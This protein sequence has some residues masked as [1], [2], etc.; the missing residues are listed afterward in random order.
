LE[1]SYQGDITIENQS[2]TMLPVH[3]RDF[4]LM[5]QDFALFPHMTVAENVAFGLRMK[6][7]PKTE[8][9]ECIN[10][11]LA[12]VGLEAFGNR[13]VTQLSGGEKQRVALARSLAPQPR[14]LML[15]EPLGSLDAGLR[16]HLVIELRD[17][18]KQVGLTS[19]YVT[20]D[21]Q[22]AYAVADRI[23]IIHNGRIEQVDTPQNL[24]QRPK[25]PFVARFLGLTNIV[26]ITAF[27]GRF[28]PNHD[29]DALLLHPVGMSISE[30]GQLRG[31]IIER[32]FRGAT[33][34]LQVRVDSET[35]AFTVSSKDPV[36]EIHETVSIHIEENWIVPLYNPLLP[37]KLKEKS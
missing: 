20:H 27:N 23:A 12:L 31:T 15:D 36:P 26:S 11:V 33:Y 16:D 5:F 19:I 13:D 25:T 32:V 34:Q 10:A 37:R 35:L 18:I 6:S 3:K 22:E 8:R 29:A 21:Q 4:G 30:N 24:Y 1:Q 28:A 2:I 7:L 9:Q 14:L 17:I